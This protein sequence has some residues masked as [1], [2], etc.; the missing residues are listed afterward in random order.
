[1]RNLQNKPVFW[2]KGYSA[3]VWGKNKV[4][5]R[6]VSFLAVF[7]F[8]NLSFLWDTCT[9]QSEYENWGPVKQLFFFTHAGVQCTQ[10]KNVIQWR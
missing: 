2:K 4:T 8:G 7:S 6:N 1:M 10:E 3:I 9:Q 5:L